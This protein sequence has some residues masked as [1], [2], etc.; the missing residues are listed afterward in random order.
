M[1]TRQFMTRNFHSDETMAVDVYKDKMLVR[2]AW[3]R[4]Y[5]HADLGPVFIYRTVNYLTDKYRLVS[6]Y[7]LNESTYSYVYV[8]Y[9]GKQYSDVTGRWTDIEIPLGEE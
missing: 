4:N 8:G 5:I 1:V 7:K 2:T 3:I 9:D 6:I